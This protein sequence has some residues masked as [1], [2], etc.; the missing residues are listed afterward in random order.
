MKNYM[1]CVYDTYLFIL[2]HYQTFAEWIF[3]SY[4]QYNDV[5]FVLF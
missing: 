3:V 2:L 5:R 4:V 1:V